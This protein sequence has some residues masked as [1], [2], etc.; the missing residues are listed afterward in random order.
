MKTPY[1]VLHD[2]MTVTLLHASIYDDALELA[3]ENF[4][5]VN[6]ILTIEAAKALVKNLTKAI[7]QSKKD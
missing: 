1:I 7:K 6:T 5:D 3:E 4:N 2:N